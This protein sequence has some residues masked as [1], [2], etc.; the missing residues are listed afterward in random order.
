MAKGGWAG[1]GSR[2]GTARLLLVAPAPIV[3]ASATVGSGNGS[4]KSAPRLS[5]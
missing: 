1:A 4:G 2:R 3:A 5:K